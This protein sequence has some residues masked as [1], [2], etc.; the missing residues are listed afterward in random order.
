[1]FWKIKL[2]DNLTAA[3]FKLRTYYV[4]TQFVLN[5]L[6]KKVVLLILNKR[7]KLFYNVN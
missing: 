7:N 5:N 4:K 3:D 1:M 2:R 6:Y